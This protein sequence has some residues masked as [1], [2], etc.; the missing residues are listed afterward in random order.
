MCYKS[1]NFEDARADFRDLKNAFLS[2]AS[3]RQFQAFEK[4]ALTDVLLLPNPHPGYHSLYNPTAVVAY[5][6]GAAAYIAVLQ[7]LYFLGSADAPDGVLRSFINDAANWLQ[8]RVDLHTS[9][10]FT[11][12][13][14]LDATN[15]ALEPPVWRF[16]CRP[17]DQTTNLPRI[18][19]CSAIPG[20][21]YDTDTCMLQY[22][23]VGTDKVNLCV[24][25]C[26]GK[27][28]ENK[29]NFG[30]MT[31]QNSG[32]FNFLRATAK[33]AAAPAARILI[34]R[35]RDLFLKN[36]VYDMISTLRQMAALQL[37][38]PQGSFNMYYVRVQLLYWYTHLSMCFP[39]ELLS[40]RVQLLRIK[41]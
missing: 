35:N 9:G 21:G 11:I 17:E 8:S 3:I 30:S 29:C 26:G 22:G 18:A 12:G 10:N 28:N 37:I 23:D 27:E 20:W 7:E 14:V 39:A 34:E 24:C 6:K 13:T 41:K 36:G 31:E 25:D 15:F 19:G 33:Q 38:M 2:K 1:Y 4:Y 5:V 16:S 40:A 32:K